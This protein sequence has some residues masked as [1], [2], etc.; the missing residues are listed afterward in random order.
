MYNGVT[1]CDTYYANIEV[2]WRCDVY[3]GRALAND[4]VNVS[5][6]V[7]KTLT[8]EQNPPLTL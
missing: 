8:Y 2:D 5:I 3:V 4:E 7:S 6:F 1:P